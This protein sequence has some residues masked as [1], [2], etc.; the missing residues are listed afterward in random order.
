MPKKRRSAKEKLLIL[1]E[2]EQEGVIVTCRKYEIDPSTYYNWKEKHE[3]GGIE[4]LK[5][6]GRN[7]QDP[8]LKA[9]REENEQLK[10][11]VAEKELALQIKE[12]L[13]KKVLQREKK[14]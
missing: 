6:Q 2:A 11:L 14:K 12:A 7:H 4:A 13:L 5:P 9:L 10:K 1:R 8:E 3:D